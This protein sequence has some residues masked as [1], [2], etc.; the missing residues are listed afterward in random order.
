[1]YSICVQGTRDA[2]LGI[3][4]LDWNVAE[5]AAAADGCI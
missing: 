2:L 1:M 3:S 4:I 5:P